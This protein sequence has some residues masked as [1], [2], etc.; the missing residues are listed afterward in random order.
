MRTKVVGVGDERLG[1]YFWSGMGRGGIC[2]VFLLR[3]VVVG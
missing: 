3:E 1:N 2:N